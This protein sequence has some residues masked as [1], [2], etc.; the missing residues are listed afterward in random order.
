MTYIVHFY[1]STFHP[2]TLGYADTLKAAKK[3]LGDGVF[4]I[5]EDK[6]NPD[7]FDGITN[8]GEVFTI[9]PKN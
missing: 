3:L 5:E 2:I 6:D 8:H 1:T 7:H 9:T 4:Q